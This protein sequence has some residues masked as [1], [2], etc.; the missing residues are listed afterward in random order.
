MTYILKRFHGAKSIP[1]RIRSEDNHVD[2]SLPK[3]D[4]CLFYGSRFGAEMKALACHSVTP[5]PFVAQC[6]WLSPC[7]EGFY[8]GSPVSLPPQTKNS[9]TND[10]ATSI[11]NAQLT[12][13][14]AESTEKNN[15]I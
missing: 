8:P 3:T 2:L 4:M 15:N 10:V 9:I 7:S 11:R 1:T 12:N 14:S 13:P 6:Y 5:D